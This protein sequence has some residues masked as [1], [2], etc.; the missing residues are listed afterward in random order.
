MELKYKAYVG[1]AEIRQF[2]DILQTMRSAV[3][4]NLSRGLRVKQP[5][6]IKKRAFP[7]ARRSDQGGKPPPDYL[8]IN[9]KENRCIDFSEVGFI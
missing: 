6:A 2:I 7:G 8:Y 1:I 3:K 9:I 4:N 5:Q